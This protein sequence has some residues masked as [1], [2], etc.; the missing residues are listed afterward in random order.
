[1]LLGPKPRASSHVHS[2]KQTMLFSPFYCCP[3][4]WLFSLVEIVSTS[5]LLP[6]MTVYDNSASCHWPSTVSF[7][8]KCLIAVHR[9]CRKTLV[10]CCNDGLLSSEHVG[11]R[12]GGSS[13]YLPLSFNQ[14]CG[15]K[16]VEH[17]IGNCCDH[18]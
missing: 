8:L 13:Q 10:I 4:L 16:I 5:K 9:S 12:G 15:G 7:P 1:M 14:C 2:T 17:L 6:Q 18:L 3:K 11:G